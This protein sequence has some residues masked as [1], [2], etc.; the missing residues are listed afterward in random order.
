MD[1]ATH[2]SH[3]HKNASDVF[4]CKPVEFKQTT[5]QAMASVEVPVCPVL[6]NAMHSLCGGFRVVSMNCDSIDSVKYLPVVYDSCIVL[7][8]INVSFAS[9]IT[10]GHAQPSHQKIQQMR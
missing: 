8:P 6:C 2:P 1:S 4:E 9:K 3:H 7:S 5:A 10:L